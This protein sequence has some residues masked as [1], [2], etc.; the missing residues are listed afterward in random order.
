MSRGETAN[1]DGAGLD[2]GRFTYG[3]MTFT[4]R[5][6]GP[7][8]PDSFQVYANGNPADIVLIVSGLNAWNLRATW[9]H[10]WRSWGEDWKLQFK[11]HAFMVFYNGQTPPPGKVRVCNE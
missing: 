3:S 10:G 8:A 7:D 5:A 6:S 4:V 9:G 1:Q 2:R 11:E